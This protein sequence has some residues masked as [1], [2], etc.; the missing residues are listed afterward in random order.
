MA[1]KPTVAPV[2]DLAEKIVLRAVE[3]IR[4]DGKDIAP[5]EQFLADPDTAAGLLQTGAV[6]TADGEAS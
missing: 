2:A 1:T 5:G 3:P 4:I 6:I